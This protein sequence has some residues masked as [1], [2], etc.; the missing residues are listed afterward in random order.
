MNCQAEKSI[1]WKNNENIKSL[2]GNAPKDASAFGMIPRSKSQI[3][4]KIQSSNFNKKQPSGSGFLHFLALSFIENVKFYI[5]IR[6]I[7]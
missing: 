3:T 2:G 1:Y 5:D 6:S 7:F 4:N